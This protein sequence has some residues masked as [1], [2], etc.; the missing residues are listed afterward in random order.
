MLAHLKAQDAKSHAQKPIVEQDSKRCLHI[1]TQHALLSIT[2]DK[3][4]DFTRLS[5]SIDG[6]TFLTE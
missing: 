1:P 6:P 4:I 3:T 2:F 5:L